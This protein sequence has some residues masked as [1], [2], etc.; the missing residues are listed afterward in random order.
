MAILKFLAI[1][2][3]IFALLGIFS[4]FLLAY[5]LKRLGRRFEQQ[6]KGY[7]KPKNEGEITVE[8]QPDNSKM[9]SKDL[10]EYVDYEEVD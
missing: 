1:L 10:G 9:V 8:G 7:G 6:Q 3:I 2:F 5:L 4:R